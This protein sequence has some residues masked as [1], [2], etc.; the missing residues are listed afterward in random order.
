MSAKSNRGRKKNTDSRHDAYATGSELGLL[1]G[2]NR[3]RVLVQ[4]NIAMPAVSKA[5]R[6]VRI[7]VEFVI[8]QS[9]S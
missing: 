3:L 1:G 4:P 6:S 9:A 5:L 2:T 8:Q 7:G